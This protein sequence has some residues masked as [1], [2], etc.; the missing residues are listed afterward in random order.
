MTASQHMREALKHLE[1]VKQVAKERVAAEIAAQRAFSHAKGAEK[2]S[3]RRGVLRT[4]ARAA[5]AE[6]PV[7]R[8]IADVKKVSEVN[9]KMKDAVMTK[10]ERETKATEKATKAATQ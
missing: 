5:R 9:A 8:G 7:K 4:A 2:V 6:K 1:R 10:A 3:L